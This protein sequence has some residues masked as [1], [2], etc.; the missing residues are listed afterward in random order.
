MPQ[1]HP[2]GLDLAAFP[3]LIGKMK[4][5]PALC[6]SLVLAAPV[7]AQDVAD[8]PLAA[9]EPQEAFPAEM[10][11][12]P[13]E[14]QDAAIAGMDAAD[15]EVPTGLNAADAAYYRAQ[16][17][18]IAQDWVLAQQ[19]AETAAAGGN[20]EASVLAGMMARDGLTGEPDFA[21]AARWFRRAAE[22]DEPIALYQLG[23]LARLGDPSLAL[24]SAGDWFERAARLGHINAMVAFAIE[25]KNSPVPQD[26]ISAREWAERAAQQGSPEGMYQLAQLLDAGTGGAVDAAGA[27]A[28]YER[29]A[30]NR[31]AEA[32]FQ[33]GMMWAAGEGGAQDDA[34]AL[35]WMRIAAE[36]GYAPAAGQYGL[37]L[38][39]GRGGEPDRGSAA[40][41]FAQ[42]AQGG[43]A[44]SQFLYA[45]ALARGDGIPADLE[46]AYGWSLLASVDALGAPVGDPDRDRLQAGLERALPQ[47]VQQRIRAQ[48]EAMR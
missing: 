48:V 9:S 11:L 2:G 4:I 7:L 30:S 23:L 1:L 6:L 21:A 29:A 10:M 14:V 5:F 33:A 41:W 26:A 35:R 28:W 38:Y 36:S 22:Q 46:A 39:Q 40:Y 24:G 19:Y 34:E 13:Q 42:G 43:D 44:E 31:H 12:L 16:I 25:Q 20:V 8:V 3:S 18:Y 32:A 27:R 37:M 45:F 47:D 17:A 15:A